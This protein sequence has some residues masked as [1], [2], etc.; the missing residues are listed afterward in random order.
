MYSTAMGQQKESFWTRRILPAFK[1][2]CRSVQIQ[3]ASI[4]RGKFQANQTVRV[5]VE[6][7][8]SFKDGNI[9]PKIV[10]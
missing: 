10:L 7:T 8:E 6:K 2:S 1:K 4:H 3:I 5:T 9:A